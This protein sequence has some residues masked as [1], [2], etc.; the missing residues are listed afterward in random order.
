MP[1]KVRSESIPESKWRSNKQHEHSLTFISDSFF[2]AIFRH[3]FRAIFQSSIFSWGFFSKKY[4]N[5]NELDIFGSGELF[6]E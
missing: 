5:V 1:L 4:W 6:H 2:R 3:F